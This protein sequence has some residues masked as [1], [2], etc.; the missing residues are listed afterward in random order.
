MTWIK[1]CG[2]T[3]LEDAEAAVEAGA[4]AVGFVFYP[5]SPRHVSAETART[6]AS[7]IPLK[8]EKIGVF[9]D[10][11]S[12]VLGLTGIQL[13]FTGPPRDFPS[14]SL[15]KYLV[16]PA[17]LKT[18]DSAFFM[19]EPVDA[20]FLDCG[21]SELPGGT[22]KTFDWKASE[23]M[24]RDLSK[25]YRLVVAGGLTPENVADAIRILKPWGVDVSSGVEA[26][27]GRKDRQKI[28]D[29]INAVRQVEV[30][31]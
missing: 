2:I 11:P 19:S 18:P 6:I 29:F 5:K 7:A 26:A 24:L 12:E 13:H 4:D 21:T 27:P 31:V 30:S 22:G 10:Q 8:I 20:L 3:N 9:V 14:T 17:N 16:L 25:K 23:P 1:I 28:R 15:K